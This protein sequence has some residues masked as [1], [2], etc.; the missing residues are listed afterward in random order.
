[1]TGFVAVIATA[2]VMVAGMAFDGGAILNAH[3]TARRVAA[4]AGRAGAQQVDIDHLRATGE[5]RLD[6]G[7]AE[8]AAR[9]FLAAAGVDG[10]ALVDG[11]EISVTV[12]V[13]H[14]LLIL[15][16]ADRIVTA[17]QSATAIDGEEP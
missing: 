14:D 1:M 16:G 13:R 17:V 3:A 2:L 6:P 9:S 7:A 4:E 10:S 15:P 12:T 5:V 8:S 11:A